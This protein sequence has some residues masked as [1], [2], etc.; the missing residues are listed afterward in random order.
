MGGGRIA[1]HGES[2]R[3]DPEHFGV[4][5]DPLQC[6]THIL[7]S[8]RPAWGAG[9]GKGVVDRDH[10]VSRRIK[11]ACNFRAIFGLVK[12]SLAATRN[13]QQYRPPS[14]GQRAVWYVDVESLPSSI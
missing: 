5:L 2:A 11:L 1:D 13:R 6:A 14:R 4:L 12:P 9:G 3:V 8:H 7:I 10:Y